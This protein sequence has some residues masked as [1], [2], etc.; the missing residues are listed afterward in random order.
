MLKEKEIIEMERKKESTKEMKIK[1]L[2]ADKFRKFQLI[3]KFGWVPWIRYIELVRFIECICPFCLS[4]KLFYR[5]H[6]RKAIRYNR[7]VNLRKYWNHLMDYTYA[8]KLERKRLDA[9]KSILSINHY[10]YD[11]F[12]LCSFDDR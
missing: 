2:K 8:R 12:Y 6:D 4:D 1:M 10:K 3:A 5:K 9:K 7:H 11:C